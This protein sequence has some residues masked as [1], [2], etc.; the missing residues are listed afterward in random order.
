MVHVRALCLLNTRYGR[1]C[2][3]VNQGNMHRYTDYPSELPPMII[4]NTGRKEGPTFVPHSRRL[5]PSWLVQYVIYSSNPGRSERTQWRWLRPCRA[6][7]RIL[8]VSSA[9]YPHF[10]SFPLPTYSLKCITTVG[11]KNWFL[12]LLMTKQITNLWKYYKCFLCWAT[13]SFTTDT[14][15]LLN[16][17][18]FSC[19]CIDLLQMWSYAQWTSFWG[20]NKDIPFGWIQTFLEGAWK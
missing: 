7:N 9:V 14:H 19:T 12:C 11:Q 5:F 1:T 17:I 2:T 18:D 20:S 13:C 8:G 6:L 3:T 10:S 15:V 4:K 16:C